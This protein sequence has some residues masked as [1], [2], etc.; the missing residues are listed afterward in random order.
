MWVDTQATATIDSTTTTIYASQHFLGLDGYEYTTDVIGSQ[1]DEDIRISNTHILVSEGEQVI[2]P[3]RRKFSTGYYY[4]DTDHG[5][6]NDHDDDGISMAESDES[7]EQIILIK[8]QAG[9]NPEEL[10]IQH[11]LGDYSFTI[12]QICKGRYEHTKLTFINRLGSFQDV[13]MFGNKSKSLSVKA[14]SWN[15]RNKVTGGGAYRP[16]TVRNV[17]QVNE[18]HTLNSGLYP[19]SN[20]VVF[21]ELMQSENV[22]ITQGIDTFPIIIKD[23]SFNFKDSNTSKAINYTISFEYAFNK[24]RSL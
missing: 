1:L 22:W 24:V 9:T 8:S 18:T 13:W 10:V 11:P 5:K 2:V 16:T 7:S 14:D 12:E 20:N 6:I 21:E 3:I 17:R 15:R 19:E 4:A 23:S